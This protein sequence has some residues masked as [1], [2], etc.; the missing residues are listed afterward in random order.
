MKE[1]LDK[2]TEAR[3]SM[4]PLGG[5]R[6]FGILGASRASQVLVS[7]DTQEVCAHEKPPIRGSCYHSNF[8]WLLG[9]MHDHLCGYASL[10]LE[11]P[12]HIMAEL[13]ISS[14][15]QH[16]PV[17]C[18]SVA[19]S[20]Q[21]LWDTYLVLILGLEICINTFWLSSSNSLPLYP[22]LWKPQIWSLFL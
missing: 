1:C 6:L 2:G 17:C 3:I 20:C 15:G 16:R 13:S 9:G 4:V 19:K 7:T 10:L 22:C 5:S 8:Y 11:D 14:L 12:F 18:C 21:T